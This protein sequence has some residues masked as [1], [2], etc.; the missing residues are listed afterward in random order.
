LVRAKHREVILHSESSLGET[1]LECYSCGSKNVFLLG[2]VPA[3]AE[4]VVVLL[5]R[6][7]CSNIPSSKDL[8]WDTNQWLPLINDR[9]FLS[10]LVKVPSED[11]QLKSRTITTQQINK[12]E[13]MWKKDR[14]ITVTDLEKPDLDEEPIPA[15]LRYQDGYEYQNIFG[16][17]VKLE[18]DYDKMV[19]ESQSQGGIVVRWD[20]GLNQ[21]RIAWFVFPKLEEGD[22]KLAVG[23]ELRLKYNGE[24]R[25]HW[26]GEGHVIKVPDSTSNEVG[27]ELKRLDNSI[28]TDCTHNFTVDYVWKSTSFDRMQ[29]AMK[30]FAISEH[31]V[32]TYIYRR[33]LGL[34]AA[35]QTIK[36]TIPKKFTAPNMPALNSSQIAAVK[37]VLQKP[38]SLIQGPPGTGKTVTSTTIV[39]HLAKNSS[40]PVLVCAPSNVAVDQL[41]EKIHR[42][43][44]KVV[45]VCAKSREALD[46]SVD[47]LTL[48]KQV[49]NNENNTEL[50]KLIQLKEEIGELGSA[51]GKKYRV[52]THLAEKEILK[53]ADVILCTC[54]GAGDHRLQRM[55]FRTVLID[56]ATQASEPESMIPLVHGCHQLIL[57]GDHQQL[58][59]VIMSKKAAKAGLNRSLFER[60]ITLRVQPQRLT[61]QYRMHPCLS[62]FPSNMFYDG[63][64]KNGIS[65]SERLMTSLDFPWPVREAPMMFHSNIGQE[66]ISSS[67]TSYLN[68]TETATCERIVTHL[69]KAGL[70]PRQI[71]VIT[72]YEG[73]RSNIVSYMQF[74]G[75][76]NKDLYREI[77]VASVDAFQGREK[78]IIILSCVRSNDHQGIGFLSDPRRLNVALTRAKYGLIILGNPKVLS[79]NP[80]WYD[81]L[82]IFKDRGHLVEGPLTNLKRSMVQFN[83]PRARNFRKD[84]QLKGYSAPGQTISS[85]A[86]LGHPSFRPNENIGYGS[87]DNTFD[88]SISSHLSMPFAPFLPP[89]ELITDSSMVLDNSHYGFMSQLTPQPNS[90]DSNE[91]SESLT[92]QDQILSTPYHMQNSYHIGRSQSD[93]IHAHNSDQFNNAYSGLPGHQNSLNAHSSSSTDANKA[94]SNALNQQ[95]GSKS[96]NDDY[97][98]HPHPLYHES[99]GHNSS[100]KAS[101]NNYTQF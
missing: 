53:S 29:L 33:L 64:L 32:S 81:L 11:E 8:S 15:L 14:D 28:P 43:G 4:T 63:S 7:P 1:V 9:S 55:T 51:D 54:A 3:K 87:G 21:K 12:L 38:I 75:S 40:T 25:N 93:K 82:T 52:L 79:K 34:E 95:D 101:R 26:E 47:F 46:S 37:S 62:E 24:L 6:H 90:K 50:Q 99:N 94:W 19:K 98:P 91:N 16:P 68:R 86:S 27:L 67:G 10:W 66:E 5:C 56:E 13:E 70:S 59:P 78:D 60:L 35:E 77:E 88:S 58:G 83:M 23:D 73:Q 20:Q 17:L 89:E 41:T 31:S 61:I 18:A 48:H 22:L 49:L 71:G 97:I 85:R 96:Q 92:S 69:L 72:P 39:Y 36:F 76:L 100:K 2:F 42:T 74:T 45:R 44:L 30:T 84:G 65:S 57:V 80:L